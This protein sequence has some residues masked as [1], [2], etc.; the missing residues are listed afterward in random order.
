MDKTKQ[1]QKLYSENYYQS[2]NSKIKI[3]PQFNI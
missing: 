2:Q 1:K 3:Q